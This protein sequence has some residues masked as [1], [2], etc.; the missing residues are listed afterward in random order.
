[1]CE[2]K[3]RNW[4]RF[5]HE[6]KTSYKKYTFRTLHKT[7]DIDFIRNTEEENKNNAERFYDI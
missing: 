6:P 2:P 7:I 1:M 4:W 3:T 5:K